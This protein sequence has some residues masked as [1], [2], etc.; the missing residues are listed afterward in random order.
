MTASPG[1]TTS[2]RE[3]QSQDIV[4]PNDTSFGSDA[5]GNSISD[6]FATGFQASPIQG[7][8]SEDAF[9]SG[10]KKF[11]SV[12]NGDG[13]NAGF[14]AD[15]DAFELE[16]IAPSPVESP[17]PHVK[18]AATPVPAMVVD[19]DPYNYPVP[20]SAAIPPGSAMDSFAQHQNAAP[21]SGMKISNMNAASPVAIEMSTRTTP[22]R[23]PGNAEQKQNSAAASRPPLF[24]SDHQNSG[25]RSAGNPAT[26]KSEASASGSGKISV[27]LKGVSSTKG[28]GAVSGSSAASAAGMHSRHGG[29]VIEFADVDAP[30]ALQATGKQPTS[31]YGNQMTDVTGDGKE[32]LFF[33]LEAGDTTPRNSYSKP[34]HKGGKSSPCCRAVVYCRNWCLYRLGCRRL[35]TCLIFLI[36]VGF[37]VSSYFFGTEIVLDE[38]QKRLIQAHDAMQKGYHEGK[39]WAHAGKELV[40]KVATVAHEHIQQMAAQQQGGGNAPLGSGAS[41]STSSPSSSPF[42]AGATTSKQTNTDNGSGGRAT[43][44][45]FAASWT[46]TSQQVPSK[47]ES[48]NPGEAQPVLGAVHTEQQ[49]GVEQPQASNSHEKDM[50]AK[51]KEME[52]KYQKMLGDAQNQ[53]NGLQS[54]V[55]GFE[56]QDGNPAVSRGNVASASARAL[57]GV[58]GNGNGG[59]QMQQHATTPAPSYIGQKTGTA[60]Q[61]N[62]AAQHN[63]WELAQQQRINQGVA[64]DPAFDPRISQ[65]QPQPGSDLMNTRI[66]KPAELGAASDPHNGWARSQAAM[67]HPNT[68][69][70]VN[71]AQTVAPTQATDRQQGTINGVENEA[72]TV[73]PGLDP[74]E[75]AEE[76]RAAIDDKHA[77]EEG[78]EDPE[79]R[80]AVDGVKEEE[81]EDGEEDRGDENSEASTT[82]YPAE[83]ED[84][85]RVAD[86]EPSTTFY[87]EMGGV[88]QQRDDPVADGHRYQSTTAIPA[89]PSPSTYPSSIPNEQNSVGGMPMQDAHLVQEPNA[90]QNNQYQPQYAAA[91]QDHNRYPPQVERAAGGFAGGTFPQGQQQLPPAFPVATTM[92]PL[93]HPHD[94]AI[95]YGVASHAQPGIMRGASRDVTLAPSSRGVGGA[96]STPGDVR[97]SAMASQSIPTGSVAVPTTAPPQA[98]SSFRAQEQ[99]AVP[100]PKASTTAIPA[101]QQQ[102][103][104]RTEV[105][106]AEARR[107]ATRGPPEHIARHSGAVPASQTGEVPVRGGGESPDSVPILDM[108]QRGSKSSKKPKKNAKKDGKSRP[109]HVRNRGV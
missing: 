9:P 19:N 32:E 47:A 42:T 76:D 66:L 61:H 95:D 77:G 84:G 81:G 105:S 38:S 37:G 26:N 85:V 104:V 98:V 21:G 73:E 51:M 49:Q 11:T 18:K 8:A 12:N 88:I 109:K 30:P 107:T 40:N 89:V 62:A 87:P 68:Q 41:G 100:P 99:R 23:A 94:A 25:N 53:I 46:R 45:P 36:L 39:K 82:P 57:G 90:V 78:G 65:Q 34:H 108:P 83:L 22:H 55:E 106:E 15:F 44:D 29:A 74:E 54:R 91:A 75:D 86:T 63:G 4:G 48:S 67:Q 28:G 101:P 7:F 71:L 69:Q 31:G 70:A 1:V 58:D 27:K 24:P 33:D 103:P 5:F 20:T 10:G 93:P 14:D 6:D 92:P 52:A 3:P 50:E 2:K 17:K 80:D 35:F 56:H 79:G 13:W 97:L 64:A 72:A 59:Q 102:F 43:N 96:S 60:M 16:A